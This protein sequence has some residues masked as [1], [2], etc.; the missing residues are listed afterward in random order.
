MTN[1]KNILV[2]LDQSERSSVRLT[3]AVKLARQHGA[4]LVGLFAQ[5]APAHA[6]GVV[7]S[8]PTEAY[9]QAAAA[10]QARFAE[11][12]GDLPQAEWRDL[13]RGGEKEISRLFTDAVRHFDLAILGQHEAGA[14]HL[15]EG[16]IEQVL[17]ESGRPLLIIP[18]S[19]RFE[20]LGTAP[21]A[22]WNESGAAARALNEALPLMAQ[23][24]SVLL[25]SISSA[26]RSAAEASC[27]A[28][29]EHL[30]A[31]GL[32]AK[33]EILT[34][35]DIGVMDALL[36]MAAD[37]GS[38]LLVIGAHGGYGGLLSGKG[39]GTRHI[40]KNMTLPVLMSN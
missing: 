21:L 1:L 39:S 19:G 13:N 3:L 35:E 12:A 33:T 36:N 37:M 27:A 8:W 18:H 28:A 22:A 26:D 34:V 6:V 30:Q 40:L 14:S 16:L 29:R 15:P 2:H 17:L 32:T 4:R 10:S 11:A 20:A 38:D 31:H 5:L 9:R 23:A 25:A 7:A 24:K